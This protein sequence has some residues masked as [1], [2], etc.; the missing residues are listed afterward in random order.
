MIRA[1]SSAVNLPKTCENSLMRSLSSGEAGASR[2]IATLKPI[3]QAS[4]T[5][6]ACAMRYVR[7]CRGTRPPLTYWLMALFFM[8]VSRQRSACVISLAVSPSRMRCAQV[9][10]SCIFFTPNE[11]PILY[12][13]SLEKSTQNQRAAKKSFLFSK[14]PVDKTHYMMYS[15]DKLNTRR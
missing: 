14:L 4:E 15:L 12:N 8:P 7:S 13:R 5:L 10:L 6:S 11:I 1:C 2:S 3:N 9:T